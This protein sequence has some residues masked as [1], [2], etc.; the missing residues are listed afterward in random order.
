MVL[1]LE[2]A[3][4]SPESLV[5]PQTSG[6][7]P[8]FLIQKVLVNKVLLAHG[9]A[10]WLAGCLGLLFWASEKDECLQQKPRGLQSLK[11]LLYVSL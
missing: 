3:A 1:K 4:Q 11:H 8:G 9:H 7:A 2:Q 6:P 5:T 10:H